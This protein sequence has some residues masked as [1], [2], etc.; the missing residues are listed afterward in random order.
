MCALFLSL[1]FSPCPGLLYYDYALTFGWEVSRY[2]GLT[3]TAPNVLFF[4]NRYGMLLGTVP[5]VFQYFWTTESTPYKLSV[6]RKTLPL[7][8]LN[9]NC[10]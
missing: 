8:I 1:L 9:A 5:V 7:L 3:A 6:S 10:F 2:W 4:L